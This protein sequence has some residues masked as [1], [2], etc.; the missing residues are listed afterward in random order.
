MSSDAPTAFFSY[1]REDSAFALRLAGDLKAAGANVWLDQLDIIPGERWARSVESALNSSPRLLVILSPASASSTNVQDEVNFALEERKTII[2]VLFRD[3]KVPFQLRPFQYV[4]FR[5]DYDRG[6][7]VMLRTLG[8]DHHMEAPAEAATPAAGHVSPPEEQ[9]ETGRA[10]APRVDQKTPGQQGAAAAPAQDAA[11]RSSFVAQQT[12][13]EQARLAEEERQ[14]QERRRAAEHERLL[15][16]ERNREAAAQREREAQQQ[17]AR[18]EQLRQDEEKARLQREQAAPAVQPGA[19]V[20]AP[21]TPAVQPGTHIPVPPPPPPRPVAAKSSAPSAGI[22]AAIAVGAV[23]VLVV[24]G[25][26]LLRPKRSKSPEPKEA[27]QVATGQPAGTNTAPEQK[28]PEQ[29]PTGATATE[30]KTGTPPPVQE[31]PKVAEKE[32]PKVGDKAKGETS[33]AFEK[34][35]E[36][37]ESLGQGLRKSSPGGEAGTPTKPHTATKPLPAGMDPKLAEVYH[38]AQGGDADAMVAL[39]FA[40]RAGKGVSKDD[41]QGAYWYRKAADKGSA[42]GMYDLGV[43]YERG[44]GV[45]KD[46]QKAF[47]LYKRAADAGDRQAM[48]NL[49]N[50]YREGLGVPVDAPQAVSWYRKGAEAGDPMGM[51]DLGYMYA[52]GTGVAR[53]YSQAVGWYSK[54]AEQGNAKAM[55]NLAFMYEKGYGVQQNSSQAI[56]WYKKAAG[57]GEEKAIASLKRLGINP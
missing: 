40:Y 8:V 34:W 29:P 39:G 35:I 30:E 17:K 14:R 7:G 44:Q 52:S 5:T 49:G 41:T 46:D 56:A 10:A 27:T 6:L 51:Y 53:D 43:L 18:Q 26:L 36:T 11:E 55:T 3:C 21:P 38:R 54:A 19:N 15:E 31:A 23:L 33:A 48:T 45:P 47:A 22:K 1:S 24:V 37:Q 12:A 4:D 50:M 57:L 32:A 13:A 20:P 16:E 2:P 42:H 28:P 9:A 25:Y